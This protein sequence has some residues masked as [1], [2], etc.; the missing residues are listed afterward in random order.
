MSSD[1]QEAVSLG[2]GEN[3]LH[4]QKQKKAIEDL[5]AQNEEAK[6]EKAQL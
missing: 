2:G 1:K 4:N 3:E 5:K 6:R